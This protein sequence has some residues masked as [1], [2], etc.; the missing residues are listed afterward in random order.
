MAT[1]AS[2]TTCHILRPHKFFSVTGI[3]VDVVGLGA[4]VF[5]FAG[6]MNKS[7][8]CAMHDSTWQ[9]FDKKKLRI[10]LTLKNFFNV[11]DNKLMLTT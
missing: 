7:L 9:V 6:G 3:G 5:T 10:A 1:N 2:P 4:S 11:T 8:F